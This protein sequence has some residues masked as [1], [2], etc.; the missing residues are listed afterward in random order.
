ME[1]TLVKIVELS[2]NKATIYS[3]RL[4]VSPDTL[5]EEFLAS[6]SISFIDE[7]KDILKRLRAIANKVGA[8]DHL[9]KLYEGNPG[10]GVCALYDEPDS[11][12]RL[13][14]IRYS[15]QIVV[16][17][18]GGPKSKEIKKLQDDPRLKEENYFLRWLSE[19]ISLRIRSGEIF[20]SAN[21]KEFKGN[22]TIQDN[23]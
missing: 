10:D 3:V 19:Q 11:K 14:C 16:V 15:T 18:S 5:I 22:L 6:N 12:L 4:D 13:Y 23:E 1:V 20:Y 9:F 8:Q 17:G 2:G 7:T 21:G